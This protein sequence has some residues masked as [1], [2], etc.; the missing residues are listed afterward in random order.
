[1]D[2]FTPP[3]TLEEFKERAKTSNVNAIPVVLKALEN[4]RAGKVKVIDEEINFHKEMEA[5][6]IDGTLPE[7]FQ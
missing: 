3:K 5:Y 1:M 7:R 6:L 2:K 4:Q